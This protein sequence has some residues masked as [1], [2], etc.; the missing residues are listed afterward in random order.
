VA[1]NVEKSQ[2]Q[3]LLVYE[4]AVV[5]ALCF[6][7]IDCKPNK[8]DEQRSLLWFAP[9]K[10]GTHWS[11]LNKT[12][13]AQAIADRRMTAAGLAKME[14]AKAD[15]S[16]SALDAAEDL[17]VPEDLQKALY[18]M[19]PAA[20]HFEAFPRSAKHGILEWIGNAK[21]QKTQATRNKRIQTTTEMAAR[22]ERANQWR[23]LG[24]R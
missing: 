7:W 15:G 14:A 22:N 23:K 24:S 17:V 2:L 9:R 18:Q 21:T 10:A 1:G 6:G 5:E 13:A 3:V 16:W 12:R 11:R 8:V 19:P 4:Q 20:A